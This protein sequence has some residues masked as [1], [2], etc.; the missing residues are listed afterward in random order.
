[1]TAEEQFVQ[2]N[3]KFIAFGVPLAVAQ[4]SFQINI[5]CISTV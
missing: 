2:K 5:E 4:A 3:R 1:M